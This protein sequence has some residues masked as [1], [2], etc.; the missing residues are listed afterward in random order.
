[1]WKLKKEVCCESRF[2]FFSFFF[3]FFCFFY[4]PTQQKKKKKKTKKIK[5]KKKK[6]KKN[7][8]PHR[9]AKSTPAGAPLS[10]PAGTVLTYT[11]HYVNDPYR[12]AVMGLMYVAAVAPNGGHIF[13]ASAPQRWFSHPSFTIV[14]VAMGCAV[15]AAIG[16]AVYVRR[17]AAAPESSFRPLT[18]L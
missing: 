4:T 18:E 6:K 2:F 14:F 9:Y 3:F 12:D 13:A 17:R 15:A 16:A 7:L 5:K 8:N 11:A 1:L 10:L